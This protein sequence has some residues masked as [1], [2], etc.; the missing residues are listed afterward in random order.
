VLMQY[1]VHCLMHHV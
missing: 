1:K